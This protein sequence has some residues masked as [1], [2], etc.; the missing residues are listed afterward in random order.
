MLKTLMLKTGLSEGYKT[1]LACSSYDW[2]ALTFCCVAI[3]SPKRL[4]QFRNVIPAHQMRLGNA[5]MA[6]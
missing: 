3:T 1:V 4:V 5:G 6:G 2:H